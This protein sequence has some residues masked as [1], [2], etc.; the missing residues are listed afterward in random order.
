[1]TAQAE[2]AATQG[3]LASPGDEALY[4]DRMLAA[5]HA[6]NTAAIKQIM[7]ELCEVVEANEPYD[8]LHP[9]TVTLF[10]SLL[11]AGTPA[12]SPTTGC[13]NGA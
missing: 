5:H 1:M 12:P 10:R 8:Q 7:N 4:R 13:I 6:G 3:L 9:E 2:W 11:G